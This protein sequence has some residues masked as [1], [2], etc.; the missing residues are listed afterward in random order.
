ML[1][2]GQPSRY[3][4]KLEEEFGIGTV[5]SLEQRRLQ[6]VKNFPFEDLIKKYKEFVEDGDHP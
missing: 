5:A 1:Y 2:N 6:I 4:Q 3:A